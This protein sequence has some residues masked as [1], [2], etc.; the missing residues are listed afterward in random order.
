MEHGDIH[1]PTINLRSGQSAPTPGG[2]DSGATGA[3]VATGTTTST[4]STSTADTAAHVFQLMKTKEAI[5][6]EL[7]ALGSVLDSVWLPELQFGAMI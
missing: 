4:T 5:E 1:S 7:K 3:T 2:E 6:E